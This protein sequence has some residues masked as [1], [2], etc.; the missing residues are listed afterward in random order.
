MADGLS[1]EE[2]L[3]RYLYTATHTN[4]Y[5]A[6]RTPPFN[7]ETV[8]QTCTKHNN[9]G[10]SVAD[11]DPGSGAFLTPGSGIRNRFFPDLGSRIPD[12]GSRISDPGSRIPD[13]GSRISDPGPGSRISDPG[14][15]SQIPNPYFCKLSDKFLGKKFYNSFKI[16]PN[17]F[18]K[19]FKNKIIYNFVRFVATKKGLKKKSFSPFS[20]VAV[21]GS[22]M[23]KNQDPG[24]GINIPDPQHSMK[25]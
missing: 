19:H 10:A 1:F 3:T 4:I 9:N 22:G 20:L 7:E 16:D 18:L 11:P 13:L 25:Q 12:L 24:S 8:G 15:G 2:K 17:F 6:G 14:P 23:D 5:A 21:F